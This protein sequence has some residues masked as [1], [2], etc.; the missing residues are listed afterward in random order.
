MRTREQ[1]ENKRRT[2]GA[3]RRTEEARE[4]EETKRRTIRAHDEQK[5][6]NIRT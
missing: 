6:K 4:Q 2:E 5:H 1:E 3:K